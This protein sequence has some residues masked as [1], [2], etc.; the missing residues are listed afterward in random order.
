MSDIIGG[1]QSQNLWFNKTFTDFIEI[2]TMKLIHF[3]FTD[4]RKI[5]SYNSLYLM[6][7]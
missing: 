3:L 7:R 4:N 6:I 2:Q 1:L 5:S